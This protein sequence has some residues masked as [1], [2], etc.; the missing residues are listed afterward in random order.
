MI[1]WTL[2]WLW[3]FRLRNLFIPYRLTK[4]WVSE[5][6]AI[7]SPASITNES[8]VKDVVRT[9]DKCKRFVPGSMCLTQAL[10]TRAVLKQYGQES[11]IRLGVT[12]SDVSFEAHAWVEVDGRI[13][14]GRQTNNSRYS[15][16][17][18][19]SSP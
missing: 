6:I 3:F 12:K 15:V 4:K 8:V 18:P 16:L 10:A 7:D 17:R 14:F 19:S 1:A 9:V 5:E 13:I 2:F 11:N